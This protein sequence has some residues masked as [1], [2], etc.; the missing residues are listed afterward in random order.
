MRGRRYPRPVQVDVGDERERL[1]ALVAC[2]IMD[3]PERPHLD[4]VADLVVSFTGAPLSIVSMVDDQRQFFA[5]QI[6]LPAETAEARGTP[7]SHSLCRFVV[8]ADAPLVVDDTSADQAL[9]Q[10]PAVTDLGIAAYC[11]VPIHDAAGHA[12]GSLAAL[13]TAPHTWTDDDVALLRSLA[14]VVSAELEADARYRRLTVD[15][16]RRL[17][18]AALPTS[19]R[20]E[21]AARYRPLE[22]DVGLGGDFYDVIVGPDGST[23]LVV[24]DIVGHDSDAAIAMGQLRTATLALVQHGAELPDIAATLDRICGSL[25][26]VFC[27]AWVAVRLDPSARSATYLSAGAIPPLV[28]RADGTSE[29]LTGATTPP[30]GVTTTR[31]SA[32]VDL[33]AGDVVLLCSDGLVEQR[34]SMLQDGLDRVATHTAA[35]RADDLAHLTER[36]LGGLDPDRPHQDDIALLLCR[37]T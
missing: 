1:A 28:V 12:L 11:G 29:Y 19:D 2:R 7:L 33:A 9:A 6:G 18:P 22:A 37:I 16:H 13:D 23:T 31:R 35:G 34:G 8:A 27:S 15:L 24:G 32:T 17:L 30:I 10:H 36:L 3:G 21:V 20:W 25:P 26:N 4:R 5:A 14:D